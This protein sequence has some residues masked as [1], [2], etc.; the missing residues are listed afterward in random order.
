ME[1]NTKIVQWSDGTYSLAIGDKFFEISIEQ[2]SN[3]Q[4]YSQFETFSLF[5]GNVNKKMIV[6]PP[7][8]SQ[9]NYE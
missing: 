5:K 6:K 3:R 9:A 1:S 4:C 7:P 2:L 8:K